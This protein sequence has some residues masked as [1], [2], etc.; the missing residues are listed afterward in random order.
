MFN[1]GFINNGLVKQL[2]AN[3]DFVPRVCAYRKFVYAHI[4]M[5]LGGFSII[6]RA[7]R[8]VCTPPNMYREVRASC[9]HYRVPGVLAALDVSSLLAIIERGFARH[10]KV[11]QFRNV[12][13]WIPFGVSA[14]VA[15][16]C[17]HH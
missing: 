3:S 13:I 8:V 15:R 2:Q 17:P 11:H 10:V 9:T 1:F 12:I 16:V 7:T 14:C 6:G 4:K 5:E